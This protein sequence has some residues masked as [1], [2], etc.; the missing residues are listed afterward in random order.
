MEDTRKV[1][2]D[3]PAPEIRAVTVR[4]DSLEKKVDEKRAAHRHAELLTSM[5]Q[6][7]DYD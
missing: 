5:R 1:L 6:I 4:I 2:Q 7:V 3:F